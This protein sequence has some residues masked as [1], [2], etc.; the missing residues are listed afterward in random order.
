[1]IMN[2]CRDWIATLWRASYKGIPFFFE[3]DD[4]EGG[5]TLK[6][7]EYPNSDN[8]DI[9]DMGQ[10]PRYYSGSAYVT[11]DAADIQAGALTAALSSPGTGTLVIP[12]LGPVQVQAMPWRR[13]SHK[14]KLGYIAFSVK[15]VRQ[16]NSISLAPTAL[17]GQLVFDAADTLS[18]ALSGLFPAGLILNL[19]ANFVISAAVAAVQGAAVAIDLVRAANPV[20]PAISARIAAAVAAIANATPLLISPVA[21]NPA[22]IANL[23]ANV[24][25]VPQTLTEPTAILASALV[26]TVR[27]L[28]DGMV[29]NPDAGAGALLGLALEYPAASANVVPVMTTNNSA[30]IANGNAIGDLMRIGALAAWCEALKRQTYASR[31]DGV[32]ARAA[33]AERLGQEIALAIGAPKAMLFSALRD[34]QGAVVSYLTQLVADLAPVVTVTAPRSMPAMWWAWRLYGDPLRAF[35][36]VLRNKVEHPSFMPLSFVALAPD[37]PAPASLPTA[38]PAP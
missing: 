4:E 29:G 11:G 27:L 14:D 36:L 37:F 20:D 31:P 3:S 32:A 19:P 22:D 35:D 34:L 16:S 15:F 7:H 23:L 33:V 8:Y 28:G 6:I 2:A 21:T 13:S 5:R 12:T 26:E 17:L 10:G 18:S 25:P 30:A 9:E 24:P 1:M 38:W